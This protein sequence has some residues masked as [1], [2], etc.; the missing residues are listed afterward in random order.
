MLSCSLSYD[1]QS[2]TLT[3]T[4]KIQKPINRT[5]TFW[6]IC[7]GIDAFRSHIELQT[8]TP[9]QNKLSHN[10][11]EKV[12][13]YVWQNIIPSISKLILVN[14]QFG[15]IL[16]GVAITQIHLHN[17]TINSVGYY[18]DIT[19]DSVTVE[20]FTVHFT[21]SDEIR[22]LDNTLENSRVQ[23]ENAKPFSYVNELKHT[24][25]DNPLLNRNLHWAYNVTGSE[26]QIDEAN[27]NIEGEG[28]D[29]QN[30]TY[31]QLKDNYGE[32]NIHIF[33]EN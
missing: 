6:K 14:I 2:L 25:G 31:A 30:V 22:A 32:G 28:V 21:Y 18:T 5:T 1:T 7:D 33:L 17:L 11:S 3:L 9:S 26:E 24:Q 20:K 8:N 23:R 29:H 13:E 4:K 10:P 16:N 12:V 19:I 27:I 15:N